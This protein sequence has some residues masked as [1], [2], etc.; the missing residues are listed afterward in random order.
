MYVCTYVSNEISTFGMSCKL[1]K[2]ECFRILN[3]LGRV[4]VPGG[5]AIL[6]YQGRK[7]LREAVKRTKGVL[8][9]GEV[10]PVNI[11]GLII[12]L[13]TVWKGGVEG[14]VGKGKEEMELK[15]SKNSKRIRLK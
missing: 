15:N 11:G 7:T 3:E 4:L 10:R 6:L 13:H 12:G 5:R 14:V 2:K 9:M 8:T 1:K